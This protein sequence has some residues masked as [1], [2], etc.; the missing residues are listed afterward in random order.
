MMVEEPEYLV[1]Y[2]S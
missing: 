2:R 1:W